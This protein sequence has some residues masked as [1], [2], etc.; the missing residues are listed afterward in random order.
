MGVMKYF[1]W[2]KEYMEYLECI[3]KKLVCTKL[4]GNSIPLVFNLVDTKSFLFSNNVFEYMYK[5][6]LSN[7]NFPANMPALGRF[8]ADAARIGLDTYQCWHIM[9]FLLVLV[10]CTDTFTV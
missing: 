1:I 9:A 4:Y 3:I 5:C 2:M 6:A 10:H 7:L 8:W